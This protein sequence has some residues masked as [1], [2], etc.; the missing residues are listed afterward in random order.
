M[1]TPTPAARRRQRLAQIDRAQIDLLRR[2][3]DV[4]LGLLS[5]IER[6]YLARFRPRMSK[7]RQSALDAEYNRQSAL[8]ATERARQIRLT[9]TEVLRQSAMTEAEYARTRPTRS[10]VSHAKKVSRFW[11]HFNRR[12]RPVSPWEISVGPGLDVDPSDTGASIWDAPLF[13]DKDYAYE[14]FEDDWGGYD[15]QDTGYHDE[16]A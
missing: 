15:F 8:A 11:K 14:D 3:D 5:Q 10:K 4:Y 13:V 16:D 9:H 12:G 2:I 6:A 1:A 7:A